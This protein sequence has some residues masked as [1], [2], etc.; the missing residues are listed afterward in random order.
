MSQLFYGLLL[1]C[2]ASISDC[3]PSNAIRTVSIPGG[4]ME[5]KT[6]VSTGGFTR[7]DW[8]RMHAEEFATLY[9]P[10]PALAPDQI[11]KTVCVAK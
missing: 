10:D 3:N 6:G 9:K 11:I 7:R 1:I 5:W 8:C 4:F 2:S